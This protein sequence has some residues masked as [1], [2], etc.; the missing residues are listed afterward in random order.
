MRIATVIYNPQNIRH[1]QIN[2]PWLAD[3]ETLVG[4][5][6]AI[7]PN[8]GLFTVSLIG[9]SMDNKAILITANGTGGPVEGTEY[10]FECGVETSLGQL[11]YDK[12]HFIMDSAGCG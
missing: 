11:N 4:A 9:I 1:Y 2:Y 6:V 10:I 12:I 3:N 5:N 8:D 7:T